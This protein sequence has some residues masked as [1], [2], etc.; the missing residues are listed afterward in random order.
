[1]KYKVI[2]YYKHSVST[3][4]FREEFNNLDMEQVEAITSRFENE[5]KK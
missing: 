3:G 4:F 1:M 2:V 5:M